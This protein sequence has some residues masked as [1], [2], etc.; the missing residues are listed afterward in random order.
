[1]EMLRIFLPVIWVIVA[2]PIGVF[3][4]RNSTAKL[5]TKRLMVTGAGLISMLAFLGMYLATPRSFSECTTPG[6]SVVRAADL[7][8]LRDETR[9]VQER[10][11]AARDACTQSPRRDDR[12]VEALD[13]LE[14]QGVRVI[15][16]TQ[17]L[18]A[19]H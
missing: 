8:R 16:G 5:E 17:R 13:A 7:Q 15:D 11:A 10:I 3:L 2:V 1:M 14:A 4:Y 12:C 9:E 18:H 6:N 19:G